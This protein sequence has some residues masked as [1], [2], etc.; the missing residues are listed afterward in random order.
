M[1][2]DLSDEQVQCRLHALE[3]MIARADAKDLPALNRTFQLLLD[4]Q[5]RRDLAGSLE[6]K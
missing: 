6:E 2:E 3:R 4:E 1:V 5:V